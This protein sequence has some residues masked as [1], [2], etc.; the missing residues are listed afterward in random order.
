M[1]ENELK[2]QI[3]S[4]LNSM[5]KDYRYIVTDYGYIYMLHS[6][7]DYLSSFASQLDDDVLKH[8]HIALD[9]I[10]ANCES[11]DNADIVDTFVVDVYENRGRNNGR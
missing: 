7:N 10:S 2:E 4:Y 5:S 3:E 1:S 6:L 8:L 9:L 11:I